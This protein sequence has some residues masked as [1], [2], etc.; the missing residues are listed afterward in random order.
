MKTSDVLFVLGVVIIPAAL[1]VF[2]GVLAAF[3]YAHPG[4]FFFDPMLPLLGSAIC[5]VVAVGAG[6]ITSGMR[7]R[8]RASVP[9]P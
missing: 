1:S 5:V 2:F 6:L 9:E 4:S 8:K 7:M 3:D